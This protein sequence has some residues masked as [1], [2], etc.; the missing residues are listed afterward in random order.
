MAKIQSQQ[1]FDAIFD[2]NKSIE[3][4]PNHAQAYQH[5]GL[6]KGYLGHPEDAISDFDEAINL[7][8]D[9]AVAYYNRGVANHEL[10]RVEEGNQDFQIALKLAEDQGDDNLKT[11]ILR[12]LQEQK[13]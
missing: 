8:K 11:A 9:Y 2:F 10:E 7:E 12:A 4:K 6:A 5:R 3:L 1:Y 13:Q